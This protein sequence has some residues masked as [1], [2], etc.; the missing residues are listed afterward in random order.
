MLMI[1]PSLVLALIVGKPIR[2]WPQGGISS[3]IPM[4]LPAS[5]FEIELEK[6]NSLYVLGN[7]LN[8]SP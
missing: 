2:E 3:N 1:N 8:S 4:S 5:S 6:T 7:V